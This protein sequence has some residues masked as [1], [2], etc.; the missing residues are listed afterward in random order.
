[1]AAALTHRKLADTQAKSKALRQQ[2][3][4][5][6]G[7]SAS[8]KLLEKHH[9]QVLRISAC[10]DGLLDRID[11]E[12][13]RNGMDIVAQGR[14]IEEKLLGAHTI[15][16]FFRSKLAQRLDNTLRDHLCVCDE[17]AWDCYEPVRAKYVATVT[18]D[19]AAAATASVSGFIKEPPLT[20]LNGGWSPYAV[21]RDTEFEVERTASAW[22]LQ[23]DFRAVIESLPVP[24][25]GVPWFQVA[26]LPDVLVVAHEVGHIV[27]W[28]FDLGAE[29]DEAV[30]A[31]NVPPDRLVAWYAWR[32]EVFAD[33]YGCMAGGVQFALAVVDFL[34]LGNPTPQS[35]T[36]WGRYPPPWLRAQ[37]LV[38]TLRE[39]HAD[40]DLLERRVTEIFPARDLLPGFE[41]DAG[42]ISS[43]LLD[44][45]CRH[46]RISAPE[47]VRAARVRELLP[48]LNVDPDAVGQNLYNEAD[49]GSRQARIL[50]AAARAVW[51]RAPSTY[52]DKKRDATIRGFIDFPAGARG[53]DISS[54]AE[55][56]A[57]NNW[58][59]SF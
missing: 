56:R 11:E 9:S 7:L 53:P 4:H 17:Y 6:R 1:M 2:L 55:A 27:E 57:L 15:W 41:H 42:T 19:A 3:E 58:L 44:C 32:P 31:S 28:D 30:R 59:D 8:G 14:A 16:E 38:S 29:L 12:L 40:V 54:D 51:E 50:V 36:G 23:K 33:L 43:A 5:W 35:V 39:L 25:L 22:S 20:F 52:L 10:L 21:S 37:L 49:P 18:N 24:L 48:P 34:A 46:L 26:Y 45:E 47:G 13:N